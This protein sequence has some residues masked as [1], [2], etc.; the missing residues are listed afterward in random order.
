MS[1]WRAIGGLIAGTGVTLVLSTLALALLPLLGLVTTRLVG[2]WVPIWLFAAL[3]MLGAV[4]GGATTGF[5]SRRTRSGVQFWGV[6]AAPGVTA[7]GIVF[8][9]A[10][11]L[12]IPGITPAHGQETNLSALLFRMVSLGGGAGFVTGA[13]LGA[14]GGVVGHLGRAERET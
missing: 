6:A 12:L 10:F 11:L 3:P 13:V 14:I 5:L 7:I 8:G 9:L 1:P 2:D 4:A